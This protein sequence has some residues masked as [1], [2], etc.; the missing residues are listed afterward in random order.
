[1]DPS[2]QWAPSVSETKTGEED[3]RRFHDDGE[4]AGE[5]EGTITLL[6]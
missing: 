1:V 2:G 6:M 5:T 3:G 4:V